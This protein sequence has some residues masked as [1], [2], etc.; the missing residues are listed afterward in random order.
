MKNAVPDRRR[1]IQSALVLGAGVAL[2]AS[3]RAAAAPVLIGFDAEL[4]DLTST[5]DEAIRAGLDFALADINKAGGVLGGRPLELVVRDNRTVP[6]RG[7]DNAI[8]FSTMKD[9][10]GFFVGKFSP[11]ALEQVPVANGNRILM[12]NPWSAADAIV[13]NGA[14]P[15]NV[16]RLS[17]KDS[18]AIRTMTR[19]LLARRSRRI[20]ILVPNSAWGRSCVAAAKNVLESS[21]DAALVGVEW[22]TWGGVKS[23]MEQYVS[24][25]RL[26]MEGLLMVCNERDGAVF[27][28]ELAAIPAGERVPVANHWGVSGGD[29]PRLAGKTLNELDFAVVQTYSFETPRNALA[30]S[31]AE[32]AMALFRQDDPSRIPSVVG[33][34]HAYDLMHLVARAINRAASTDVAAVRTALENLPPYE[35]VIRRYAPAFTATRHEA[36]GPDELFMARYTPDGRLLRIASPGS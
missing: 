29:L 3:V 14:Q 1:F 30:R 8:E 17:L 19:H 11:V 10:V 25:R 32:R 12:F 21:R 23:F 24:L 20:G 5:S 15:N 18:W 31:L 36:L 26:G 4:R 13:D 22:F 28:K 7:V 27:L 33:L 9:M 34:A 6:A 2:P 35:G 16:F